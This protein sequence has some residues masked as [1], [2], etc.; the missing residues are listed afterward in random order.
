MLCGNRGRAG[1]LDGKRGRSQQRC[2][3]PVFSGHT[4][5]ELISG[6]G[7]RLARLTSKSNRQPVS[8]ETG[9]R[10]MWVV[11]VSPGSCP[12][13][14]D[15][16]QTCDW[17]RRTCHTSPQAPRPARIIDEGSGTAVVMYQSTKETPN[18]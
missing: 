18:P 17:R 6:V 13:E 14:C 4:E 5:S 7:R 1:A 10:L 9:C 12:G 3:L 8:G 11:R 16:A 2:W 15:S